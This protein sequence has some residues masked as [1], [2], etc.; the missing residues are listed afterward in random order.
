M[1]NLRYTSSVSDSKDNNR[2]NC[3]NCKEMKWEWKWEERVDWFSLLSKCSIFENCLEFF[4]FGKYC[5]LIAITNIFRLLHVFSEHC[6]HLVLYVCGFYLNVKNMKS[7]IF[8]FQLCPFCC[9]SDRINSLFCVIKYAIH[10]TQPDERERDRER[11]KCWRLHISS[12]SI[13]FL[14][15]VSNERF[16]SL[17]SEFTFEPRVFVNEIT[18]MPENEHSMSMSLISTMYL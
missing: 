5:C 6:V 8:S 7:C 1:Q 11:K 18:K 15:S 14:S 13:F 4:F 16:D 9:H 17:C 10:W 12:F 2:F 3:S